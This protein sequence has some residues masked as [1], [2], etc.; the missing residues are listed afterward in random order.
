MEEERRYFDNEEDHGDIN[1]NGTSPWVMAKQ[2]WDPALQDG[3]GF[4]LDAHWNS[5]ELYEDIME[6]VGLVN[7]G[8]R[9]LRRFF[10]QFSTSRKLKELQLGQLRFTRAVR[11][12]ES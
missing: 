8:D 1:E 3:T 12:S 5:F 6:D 9:L 7:E 2:Q 4:L 11:E 10:R